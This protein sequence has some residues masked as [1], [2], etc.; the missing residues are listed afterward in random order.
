MPNINPSTKSN[1]E[2]D[3]A[4]WRVTFLPKWSRP[5]IVHTKSTEKEILEDNVPISAAKGSTVIFV[6]VAV[7]IAWQLFPHTILLEL[8]SFVTVA[9]AFYGAFIA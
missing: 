4:E 1:L 7:V 6:I 2:N 8:M 3:A 9:I 5:K